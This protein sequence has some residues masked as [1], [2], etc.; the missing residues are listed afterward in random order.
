[1][2]DEFIK[3]DTLDG[4]KAFEDYVLKREAYAVAGGLKGFADAMDFLGQSPEF[5]PEFVASRARNI[6]AIVENLYGV[7]ND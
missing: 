6:A 1:M 2:N 5:G 4:Q 3:M 7:H